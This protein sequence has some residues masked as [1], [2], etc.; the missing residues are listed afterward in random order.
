VGEKLLRAWDQV[1]RKSSGRVRNFVGH[2]RLRRGVTSHGRNCCYKARHGAACGC[3]RQTPQGAQGEGSIPA[4]LWRPPASSGERSGSTSPFKW[5]M[6]QPHRRGVGAAESATV[7]KVENTTGS[8]LQLGGGPLPP[9]AERV[10]PP[11]EKHTGAIGLQGIDS[12]RRGQNSSRKNAALHTRCGSADPTTDYDGECRGAYMPNQDT[13]CTACSPRQEWRLR[14]QSCAHR[15]SRQ[16]S[17]LSDRSKSGWVVRAQEAD[18]IREP[19]HGAVE[20]TLNADD[21]AYSRCRN[22]HSAETGVRI[23]RG[24]GRA[25]VGC[26]GRVAW[27]INYICLHRTD[28]RSGAFRLMPRSARA[29]KRRWRVPPVIRRCGCAPRTKWTRAAVRFSPPDPDRSIL[30]R[31]LRRASGK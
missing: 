11:F 29:R 30:G 20:Y 10:L 27:S 1:L 24:F 9:S 22:R 12:R 4:S 28:S 17:R 3:T 6:G 18:S 31:I 25:T 8:R 23:G 14:R 7:M 2:S 19:S 5:G 15:T 13:F 26:G 21:I 16:H